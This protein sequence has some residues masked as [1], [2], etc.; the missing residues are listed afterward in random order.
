LTVSLVASVVVAIAAHAL[1][2]RARQAVPPPPARAPDVGRGPVA[3]PAELAARPETVDDLARVVRLSSR[4]AGDVHHRLRPILREV[5][6]VRLQVRGV[7]L[8]AEPA[9]AAALL[10]DDLVALVRADRPAPAD[11]FAPGMPL[12]RLDEHLR[13]LEAL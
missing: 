6:V 4:S 13:R 11:Y 3:Q 1:V 5:A 7:D 10:G 8:D 2:R 12:G 9:K